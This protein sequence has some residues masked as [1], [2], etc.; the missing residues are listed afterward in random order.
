MIKLCKNCGYIRK[1][2]DKCGAGECPR[3]G[4]FY[5][6]VKKET[7]EEISPEK[8]DENLSPKSLGTK[9]QQVENVDEIEFT[10][11]QSYMV[12]VKDWCY[13]RNFIFRI[14]VLIFYFYVA[15]QMFFDHKHGSIFNGI[16]LGIHEAGHPLFSYLGHWL[17]AAGGTILQWFAPLAC[18]VALMKQRDYFGISFAMVWF[19]A[20]MVGTSVYMADARALELQLVTI[21]GGS[22]PVAPEDI[23]D[24]H[25]LFNSVGLLAW[26]TTIA[27][28]VYLG[29]LVILVVAIC[30]GSLLTW[31]M[32]EGFK[33]SNQILT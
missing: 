28:M 3:C 22:G 9:D 25:Y 6:K 14:P 1:P 21:G 31:W 7:I 10:Y 27:T 19:A 2:T 26:D 4:A 17:H 20:S 29:A 15:A 23:H 13:S 5:N 33:K 30:F 16:N 24:W 18:G 12:E 11:F 32:F 8:I